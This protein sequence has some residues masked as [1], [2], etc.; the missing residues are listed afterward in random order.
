MEY[1]KNNKKFNKNHKKHIKKYKNAKKINIFSVFFVLT[2][3]FLINLK[4]NINKYE[5]KFS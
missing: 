2:L 1:R 4:N 3:K 5:H